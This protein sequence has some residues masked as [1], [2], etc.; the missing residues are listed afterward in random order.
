MST[1][2][3]CFIFFACLAVLA[4]CTRNTDVRAP[5]HEPKLVL[6]GYVA[7]GERFEVSVGRTLAMNVPAWDSN[8]LVKNAWVLLYDN[9]VFADSLRYDSIRRRYASNLVTAASGHTYRVV[10]GVAGMTSV[11]AEATAPEP[12]PAISVS[13]IRNARLTTD[14]AP[15]NDI[16]F[17]FNDPAG[18][19]FY[20][21]AVYPA[22][23]HGG[24]LCVYTYEPSIEKYTGELLAFDRDACIDNDEILFTDRSFSGTTKEI[25]LSADAAQMES[26]TDPSG[27][28]QRPVLRR[29]N[30][31]EDHYRYFKHM[32]SLSRDLG[33]PTFTDP[34]PVKGNVRNG[35]GLFSVFAASVDSLP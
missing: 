1:K 16:R 19:N 25:I 32:I 22:G 29:L 13:H 28:I 33:G 5:A 24:F 31:S 18:N 35:Y 14:G 30:V 20:L 17:R 3:A 11:D 12:V 4:A 7:V 2:T 26:Y 10:A 9:G 34:V 6:H 15:L 8:A 21:A 27:N 23:S